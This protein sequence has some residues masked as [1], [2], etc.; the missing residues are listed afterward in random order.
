MDDAA[1]L[2]DAVRVDR[3]ELVAPERPLASSSCPAPGLNAVDLLAVASRAAARVASE[4][5]EAVAAAAR[6]LDSVARDQGCIWV[7]GDGADEHAERLEAAGQRALPSADLERLP[8]RLG[9]FDALLVTVF[10]DAPRGL[11]AEARR[12]RADVIVLT[13]PSGIDQD[14][15]IVIRVRCFD[16]RALELTHGLIV[17]ALCPEK[18]HPQEQRAEKPRPMTECAETSGPSSRS[19]S[20]A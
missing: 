19:E 2:A 20:A 4:Q 18:Q 14:G 17:T 6:T 11:L 15:G 1:R 3:A 13:G 9:P 12:R 7:A 5:P 16:E 8:E 10:G